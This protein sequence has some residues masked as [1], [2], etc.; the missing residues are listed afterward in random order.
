MAQLNAHLILIGF[1][2][3]RAV[4][5]LPEFVEMKSLVLLL[6]GLSIASAE[7]PWIPLFNGKDLSGWTPKIRHHPLGENFANT[8]TVEDGLLKASY[9]GYGKFDK[10][11]GHLYTDIAYSRYILRMEYRFAGEKMADAPDY[12]NLNSGIDD[13]LAVPSE[14]DPRPSVSR[15]HRVSVPR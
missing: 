12:V 5:T 1:P 8:F 10:K 14:H 2:P 6:A 4:R 15:Q 3:C 13:P 11:F 7:S 9:A